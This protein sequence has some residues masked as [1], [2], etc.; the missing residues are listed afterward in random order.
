LEIGAVLKHNAHMCR[1]YRWL[2]GPLPKP[3]CSCRRLASKWTPLQGRCSARLFLLLVVLL[4]LQWPR[5]PKAVLAQTQAPLMLPRRLPVTQLPQFQHHLSL[6]TA[7]AAPR[8]LPSQHLRVKS[9]LAVCLRRWSSAAC[10]GP[11]ASIAW[12]ALMWLSSAWGRTHW[13]CSSPPW[14]WYGTT[15]EV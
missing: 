12:T 9:N 4:L 8:P 7:A 11:I 6:L 5:Q 13:G 15:E 10:C 2:A 3:A 14:A 1:F